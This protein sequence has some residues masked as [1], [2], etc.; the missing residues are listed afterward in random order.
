M[1]L[2]V[3]AV[4]TLSLGLFTKSDINVNENKFIGQWDMVIKDTPNGDSECLFIVKEV[5]GKLNV[6]L[7]FPKMDIEGFNVEVDGTEMNF[8]FSSKG[9]DLS[10]FLE[11]IDDDT[12]E[13]FVHDMFETIA[14][15]KKDLK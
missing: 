9:N 11:V 6:I 1:K 10:V 14:I 12:L 3:I 4:L 5:E 8:M 7:K 2:I 13:G 15:R